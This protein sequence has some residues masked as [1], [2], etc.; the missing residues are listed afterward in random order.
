MIY[1]SANLKYKRE[2]EYNYLIR[3]DVI[4]PIA[5]PSYAKQKVHSHEI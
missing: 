1:Q 3:P 4:F 5:G 2:P